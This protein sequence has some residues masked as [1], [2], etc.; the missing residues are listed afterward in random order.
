MFGEAP[1]WKP[2]FCMSSRASSTTLSV[3]VGAVASAVEVAEPVLPGLLAADWVIVPLSGVTIVCG[4]AVV[5]VV[6][7]VEAL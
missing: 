5:P 7:V 1:G 6:A 2:T 3:S 4:L